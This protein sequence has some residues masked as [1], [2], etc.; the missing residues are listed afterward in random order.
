M[1]LLNTLA[2]AAEVI[3]DV[4]DGARQLDGRICGGQVL[5]KRRRIAADDEKLG[6]SQGELNPGQNVADKPTDGVLVGQPVHRTG[7]HETVRTRRDGV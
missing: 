1:P 6:F 2:A 3:S 7:E 4:V 5:E